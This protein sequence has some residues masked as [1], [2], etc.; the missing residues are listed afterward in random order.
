MTIR[1]VIC[2][3]A[4]LAALT[5][6]VRGRTAHVEPHES[7]PESEA[8]VSEK[9]GICVLQSTSGSQVTGVVRFHDQDGV[10]IINVTVNGLLPGS[11]HA[12]HIHELGDMRAADGSSVGGHYNPAGHEHGGPGSKEH[13]AG[14]LGNI[15]ADGAGEAR[16]EIRVDDMELG[17]ILGRSVVIHANEDDLTSQPAGNAGPRIGVGVIGLAKTE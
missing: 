14:D 11:K 8:V 1:H 13:H 3:V 7:A 6:C 17:E 16:V 12:M 5:A 10:M 2:I 9:N 4:T 15:A